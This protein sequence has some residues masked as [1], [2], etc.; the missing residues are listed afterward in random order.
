MSTFCH[1]SADTIH[2]TG[3]NVLDFLYK[4]LAL[5]IHCQTNLRPELS[6][7]MKYLY[8]FTLALSS[9]LMG[10]KK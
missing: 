8:R 7:D 2:L 5:T 4:K 6:L 1:P 10:K 3:D 9:F